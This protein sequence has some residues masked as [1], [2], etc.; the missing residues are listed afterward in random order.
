MTQDCAEN[1][2]NNWDHRSDSASTTSQH[3]NTIATMA[4]RT[5]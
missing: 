4:R 1:A 5:N 3:L 2:S